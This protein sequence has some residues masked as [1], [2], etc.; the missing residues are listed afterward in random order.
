MAAGQKGGRGQEVQ[1][2]QRCLGEWKSQRPCQG[3]RRERACCEAGE[4][5][6]APPKCRIQGPRGG[7]AEAL[8]RREA[9]REGEVREVGEGVTQDGGGSGD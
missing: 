9:M 2:Q 1:E 8:P 3:E 5:R 6:N 7:D 4:G